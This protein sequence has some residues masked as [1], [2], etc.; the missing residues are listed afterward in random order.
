MATIKDVAKRAGVSISTVSNVLNEKK[1]VS[2]DLKRRVLIAV[3]ELNYEVDPIARNMKNR[4]TRTI[5]II[6][7]DICGLFYPYV[8]KGVYEIANQL[9]YQVVIC[10]TA[11][12]HG[13]RDAIERE[14]DSFDRLI[15]NRVDGIIFST[16]VSAD[17]FG[18]YF[19]QLKKKAMANKYIPL[20]SVEQDFSKFGIDS[21]YYEGRA[22][23]VAATNHLIQCG[24]KK[25]GHVTGPVFS[26]IANE[27]IKGYRDAMQKAKLKVDEDT[28]I[29]YGDYS[30]Q[31][32]YTGTKAL[33][34]DVPDMDGIFF[35]NDQMAV[36][37][38]KALKELGKR[39]PEDIK[40]IGYDDVFISSVV[41][42]PL[43]TIHVQKRH[44][45]IVAAK[46]LFERIENETENEKIEAKRVKMDEHLVIRRSSV[47]D[48]ADDWILSDW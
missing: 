12:V 33:L 7:A 47:A 44:V 3:Q 9:G 39:V 46:L 37:A 8:I 1:P 25:I 34:R 24:C 10:D 41:E 42:P 5:G 43:S 13:R 38:L 36:G 21:V 22:G 30:H 4:T 27:R 31:S 18:E 26:N 14:R 16:V 35:A 11:G 29:A 32:G 17:M 48:A 23:A 40:I 15:A 6:T 45:G 28:M 20:V 2:D 19:R